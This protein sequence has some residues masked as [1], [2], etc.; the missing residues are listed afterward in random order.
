MAVKLQTIKDI[1]KFL[2]SELAES[3]PE[4]E[5]SSLSNII[6]TTVL[7]IT[8]PSLLSNGR[9]FVAPKDAVRIIE[10]CE[11][12]KSGRPIQY[13]LGET[14]FYGCIIMVRP[15]VLIPRPETEELVDL[16]IKENPGFNGKILDIGTGSGCIAVA[17]AV[18][19]GGSAVTG[20]DNSPEAI[21]T[22][23]E[24]AIKNNVR[25]AL[26]L[27]DILKEDLNETGKWD[28]VV[29][30]PPYVRNSEKEEMN[31][32]VLDFEPHDA[33]FVLDSDPLLFYRTILEKSNYLL[34]PGG[35][36]YFEINEAM[37]TQLYD[38]AD[39]GGYKSISV[40]KDIN[41]KDRILKAVKSV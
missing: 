2:Y 41:G 31:R 17:L 6:F 9:D 20:V 13:I 12:L 25:I 29:S 36:I 23:S 1:R 10:I 16:I 28:I 38:L 22:A 4:N 24:N 39:S 18:N 32:N 27:A 30:N 14:L 33:L 34:N 8:K 7:G 26:I 37:G 40:I 5:I 21:E 15:G 3:Y 11:E 35:R 19:L